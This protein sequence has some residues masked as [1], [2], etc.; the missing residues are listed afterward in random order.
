MLHT[1]GT[2]YLYIPSGLDELLHLGVQ[3]GDDIGRD[4][5]GLFHHLGEEAGALH[6]AKHPGRGGL[7]RGHHRLRLLVGFVAAAAGRQ[8]ATSCRH[9]LNFPLF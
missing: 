4:G 3:R 5:A 6:P 2:V 9:H 7:H 8:V 1:Y